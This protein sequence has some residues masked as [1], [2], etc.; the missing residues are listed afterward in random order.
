MCDCSK[1]I[2]TFGGIVK[3]FDESFEQSCYCQKRLI[4]PRIEAAIPSR[5]RKSIVSSLGQLDYL[6]KHVLCLEVCLCR[7]VE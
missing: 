7:M 3:P 6:Y 4:S 1:A 2:L 5:I